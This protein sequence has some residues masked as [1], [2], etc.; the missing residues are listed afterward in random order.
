[1]VFVFI[2][3]KVVGTI[4]PKIH[5]SEW[6]ESDWIERMSMRR[7]QLLFRGW[8]TDIIYL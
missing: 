2:D 8:E 5:P 4:G 1:M 3:M 7:K 6:I